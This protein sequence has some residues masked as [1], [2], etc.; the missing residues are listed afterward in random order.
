MATQSK[1]H[2]QTDSLILFSDPSSFQPQPPAPPPPPSTDNPSTAPQTTSFG[3]FSFQKRPPLRVTTE[4][5]SDSSIFFHKISSKLFNGF[6]KLKLS[7]Q[8]NPKGEIADPQV[9]IITK[10]LA[11]HY[12]IEEQNALVKGF[13][14]VGPN[15]KLKAFHD[16]KVSL[17]LVFSVYILFW[18]V[19]KLNYSLNCLLFRK[20]ID[21]DFG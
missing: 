7:F 16:V 10:H 14:D 18:N 11:F 9:A 8:N 13:L 21:F 20:Y 3:L 2:A 19:I 12:D 4:F 5:D 15:L 1:P 17:S 6:A